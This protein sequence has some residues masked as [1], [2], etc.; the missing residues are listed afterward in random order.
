MSVYFDDY[1]GYVPGTAPDKFCFCFRPVRCGPSHLDTRAVEMQHLGS[2]SLY[3]AHDLF[4]MAHQR[5]PQAHHVPGR[6]DNA[7]INAPDHSKGQNK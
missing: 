6:Q 3:A 7:S 5:D 1:P 2:H 4:L